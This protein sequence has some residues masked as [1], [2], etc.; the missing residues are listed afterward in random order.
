MEPTEVVE[1]LKKDLSS[2]TEYEVLVSILGELR[3]IREALE[4]QQA[5]QSAI[6]FA[7]DGS[8]LP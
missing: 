1:R 4:A 7:V 5:T 3:A 6:L 8:P 2:E